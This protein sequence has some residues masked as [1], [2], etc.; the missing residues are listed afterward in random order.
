MDY[1]KYYISVVFISF[2]FALFMIWNFTSLQTTWLGAYT[3]NKHIRLEYEFEYSKVY[4]SKGEC[5]KWV[6]EIKTKTNGG[7]YICGKNCSF[8]RFDFL[9]CEK[10][11]TY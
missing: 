8:N 10:M 1:T 7:K 3:S 6:N 11:F 9:D 4:F 5:E 2:A